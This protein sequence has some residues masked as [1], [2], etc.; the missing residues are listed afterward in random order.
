MQVHLDE[1]CIAN[2]LATVGPKLP[3]FEGKFRYEIGQ[4]FASTRSTTIW[5][6]WHIGP[7]PCECTRTRMRGNG[8]ERTEVES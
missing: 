6:H 7:V 5:H 4:P 3:C 2:G 8:L 1:G